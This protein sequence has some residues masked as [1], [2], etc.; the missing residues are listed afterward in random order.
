M[1]NYSSLA[2]NTDSKASSTSEDKRIL[3]FSDSYSCHSVEFKDG[4]DENVYDKVFDWFE[5]QEITPGNPEIIH[6]KFFSSQREA[7]KGEALSKG[8]KLGGS[9]LISRRQ[10]TS[11][12]KFSSEEIEGPI[13][14]W[15]HNSFSDFLFHSYSYIHHG[16]IVEIEYH[17]H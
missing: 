9:L 15:V 1:K 11:I 12:K 6:E 3:N 13:V 17:S 5:K 7:V 10:K 8:L 4:E 16:K 14:I 2:T